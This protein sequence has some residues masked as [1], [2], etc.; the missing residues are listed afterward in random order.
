[1]GER[2]W[3]LLTDAALEG[4]RYGSVMLL[5]ELL[6]KPTRTSAIADL[7]GLRACLGH[8]KLLPVDEAVA[9]LAVNLGAAY[10]LRAADA[11]HLATAVHAGADVFITNNRKDFDREKILELT[12][13]HPDLL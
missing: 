12:V 6:S 3:A 1:M 10:T 9:T 8:L 11:V 13:V 4:A 2:V 5:P 7:Q